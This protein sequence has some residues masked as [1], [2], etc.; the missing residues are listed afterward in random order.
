MRFLIPFAILAA[1]TC[2][3][4]FTT[5][6]GGAN[7]QYMVGALAADSAGNTYVTGGYA[8]VTKLDPSGN[9]VFTLPVGGQC[10]SIGLAI[11]VDPSGDIWVGGDT[12]SPNLPLVNALQSTPPMPG[13]T[14]GLLVKM[15]PDGT[16]LY[17]ARI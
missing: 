17:W 5:Y 14:I 9:I 2:S 1:A 7:D 10:C 12:T 16:I 3:A 4:D 15:A 6:V 11:A 8:F 13:A